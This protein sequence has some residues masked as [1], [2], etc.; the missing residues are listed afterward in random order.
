MGGN[1]I[2]SFQQEVADAFKNE[3]LHLDRLK[4]LKLSFI[5]EHLPPC[6]QLKGWYLNC[7]M[8]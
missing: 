7:G 4:V 2:D 1:L 8:N 5:P 3:E 6:P